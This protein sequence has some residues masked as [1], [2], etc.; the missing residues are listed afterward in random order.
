MRFSRLLLLLLLP[1]TLLAPSLLGLD[2]QSAADYHNRR[3]RLSG[4]LN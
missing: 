2:H 3:V 4:A 1:T